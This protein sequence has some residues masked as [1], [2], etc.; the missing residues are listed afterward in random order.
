MKD[1]IKQNPIFGIYD[2][3]KIPELV[4]KEKSA[5]VKP[6]KP[7]TFLDF[8]EDIKKKYY[9]FDPRTFSFFGTPMRIMPFPLFQTKM[10]NYNFLQ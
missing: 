4:N 6:V 2:Q 10:Y 3:Y 5:L 1:L 8:K 9:N 7:F